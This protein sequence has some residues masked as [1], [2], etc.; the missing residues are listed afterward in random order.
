MSNHDILIF[1]NLQRS[2][3]VPSIVQLYRCGCLKIERERTVPFLSREEPLR[4]V[5]SF[6]RILRRQKRWPNN[7]FT[8]VIFCCFAGF[9]LFLRYWWNFEVEVQ[10]LL[11]EWMFSV[12]LFIYLYICHNALHT[13]QFCRGFQLKFFAVV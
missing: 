8:R 1:L 4:K 3:F 12:Y 5:E 10:S 11:Y 6:E 9:C 2:K 7:I 13:E